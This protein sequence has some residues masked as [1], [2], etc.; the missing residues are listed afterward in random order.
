MDERSTSERIAAAVTALDD[1][2]RRA[3]LELVS[4]SPEL[5]S[6]DQAAAA[7]RLPRSTVAFHL[8]RLADAGLVEVEYQRLSGK[9]GPG[10]GRPAK[11]YRRAEGEVAVSVPERHYEL[12]AELLAAAV[13]QAGRSGEPVS[14]A[15]ARL[16]AE[17]GRAMGEVA[18]SLEQALED[19][20]FEPRTEADGG[21]VL[22]NC[23]FHRLAR[24]HTEIV[25]AMNLDLL[26][27]V[28]HG[29]GDTDH[30]MLLDPGAGRCCVRA[31]VRSG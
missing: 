15:L 6:R 14:A 10:A 31:G 20:G 16:A 11:L 4:R 12:A 8:D 23:P 7:M 25:C 13:E 28:A 18:G 1:P 9:T 19:N 21:I 17:T 30:V 29:A 2:V 22:G 3:L 26:R 5:V 24:R 27:G